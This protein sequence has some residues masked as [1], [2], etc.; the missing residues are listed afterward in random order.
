MIKHD[1]EERS[2]KESDPESQRTRRAAAPP[3]VASISSITSLYNKTPRHAPIAAR[4]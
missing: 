1:I 4:S 3:V 2:I